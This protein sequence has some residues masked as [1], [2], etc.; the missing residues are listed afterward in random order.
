M[1]YGL[2]LSAT[3]VMANSFR[4]DLI[5]NNLANV[6]TVGYKRDNTSFQQRLTEAQQIR[7]GIGLTNPLLE[8]IGGGLLVSPSNT[9]FTQGE[10]ETTGNNLDVA[11]VGNGYFAVQDGGETRLTRDGQFAIDR[12]GYLVLGKNANQRVLDPDLR[13]IQLDG[14]F[15]GT[16]TIGEL[17]ELTQNDQ[18]AGRIGVFDADPRLLAKRGG[19]LLSVTNVNQLRPATGVLRSQFIERSNVDP[20]MELAQLM[21][22]QRQLEANANM[23]RYQDQTLGRL[24]NDV[25]KMT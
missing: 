24:V 7:A 20:T 23:I 6:E 17:G 10:L 25:G 9:D 19:N 3:G 5:A 15:R 21:D 1:N 13:P 2:Y 12:D 22:A 14:R 18:P 8:E 16:V 4:Q 11:V